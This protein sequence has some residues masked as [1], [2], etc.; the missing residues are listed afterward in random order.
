MFSFAVT[1]KNFVMC[2]EFIIQSQCLHI[3]YAIILQKVHAILS[4]QLDY[5]P[6][7]TQ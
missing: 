3:L 1:A 2:F 7:A 5:A 6:H 4:K